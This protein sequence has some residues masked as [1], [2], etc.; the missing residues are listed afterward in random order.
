MTSS[1][2][3]GDAA[4]GNS[5]TDTPRLWVLMPVY[6]D[7]QCYLRLR[8]EIEQ[9]LAADAR[10]VQLSPRYVL[11]DDSAGLDPAV[12]WLGTREVVVTPP[13]NLGH[14]RVIVFGLRSLAPQ[15][16]DPDIVVTCDSDGQDRPED[17]PSLLEPLSR[18]DASPRMLVLAFRTRRWET[19]PFKILYQFFKLLFR[20]LTGFTVRTGNFAAFRGWFARN[21][22]FHPHFDLCYSS[23]LLSFKTKTVLVP[24]ERGKRYFGESH[25][26][27]LPLLIHGIRMLMPF[28]DRIAIR[29]LVAFSVIAG[30]AIAAFAI[31]VVGALQGGSPLP[32]GATFRTARHSG[33]VFHRCGELRDPL[34]RVLAIPRSF[35]EGAG[36]ALG[37]R[38]R[39]LEPPA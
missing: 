25:M 17:L 4:A 23:S 6:F 18:T 10:C 39:G 35:A 8:E 29:A 33:R 11:V 3:L 16:R 34:R 5:R 37:A 14:Q 19:L 7:V 15:L 27:Y 30:L 26:G 21:L 2:G 22:L 31:A 28:L 13:F 36:A 38:G 9:V 20:T 32:A 12:G 1:A 24:C